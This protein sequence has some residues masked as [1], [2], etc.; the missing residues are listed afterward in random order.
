M[1]CGGFSLKDTSSAIFANVRVW[2]YP[3]L[4][5]TMEMIWTWSLFFLLCLSIALSGSYML[6]IFVM[7]SRVLLSVE[8]LH[9]LSHRHLLPLYVVSS[10]S[11]SC[12]FLVYP[13]ALMMY[14]L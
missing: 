10:T 14:G 8:Y 7:V 12:V 1:L 4:L 13:M 11:C 3:V 5:T 2:K 6:C 9:S